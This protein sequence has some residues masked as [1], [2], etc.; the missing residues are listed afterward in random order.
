MRCD[1][2]QWL[3]SF[4]AD[5]PLPETTAREVLEHQDSCQSCASF[6]RDVAVLHQRLRV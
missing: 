5:E 1:A 2:A 3:L 4:A 6:A